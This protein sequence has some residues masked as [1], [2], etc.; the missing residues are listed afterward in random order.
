MLYEK[1]DGTFPN[2][3]PDPTVEENLQDLKDLIAEEKCDIGIAL[4]GDADRIGVVDDEGEVLWGDQL[5][6]FY[7]R[8]I[9][10]KN[11][12]A[13]IIAD[14]KASKIFTEEVKKAGG[15]PFAPDMFDY[16]TSNTFNYFSELNRDRRGLIK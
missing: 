12:G 16:R 15:N 2:H 3:H 6:I 13:P 4:D 7:A 8:E 14:V 5:L 9:L 10:E 1:V 11:Q